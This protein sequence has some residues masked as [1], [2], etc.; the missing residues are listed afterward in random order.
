MVKVLVP[1][2][3]PEVKSPSKLKKELLLIVDERSD[4][5]VSTLPGRKLFTVSKELG[6]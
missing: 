6:V 2:L 4:P 5:K 1:E 3:K